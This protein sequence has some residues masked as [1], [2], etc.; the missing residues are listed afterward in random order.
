MLHVDVLRQLVGFERLLLN[1]VLFVL[2]DVLE[3]CLRFE[4]VPVFGDHWVQHEL[5]GKRTNKVVGNVVELIVLQLE[6]LLQIHQ[7]LASLHLQDTIVIHYFMLELL[8]FLLRLALVALLLNQKHQLLGSQLVGFDALFED[9]LVLSRAE[10]VC[11]LESL[12]ASLHL[13]DVLLVLS[14]DAETLPDDEVGF[15][16]LVVYFEG[17]LTVLNDVFV[18]AQ[19]EVRLGSVREVNFHIGVQLNGFGIMVNCLLVILVLIAL[20]SQLSKF[21]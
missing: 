17:A 16:V 14:S 6:E 7:V 4:S 9:L 15:D 12:D 5:S 8:V 20:I 11:L 18:V 13:F 21:L 1:R 2:F 3:D 10:T 19:F